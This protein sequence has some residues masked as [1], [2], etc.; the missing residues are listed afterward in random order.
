MFDRVLPADVLHEIGMQP[1]YKG[2]AYLLFLLQQTEEHPEMMYDLS[3]GLYLVAMR[4][5]MITRNN[6]E[7]NMRFAIRRTWED[8]NK[9]AIRRIFGAYD[10]HDVPTVAEAIT[11]LTECMLCKRNRGRKI[12]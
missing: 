1:K 9:A 5:F 7:R 6:L 11:I 8:G 12:P 4:H 2:Y 3:R 10:M